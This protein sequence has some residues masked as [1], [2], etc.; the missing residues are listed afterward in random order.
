MH[1]DDAAPETAH[2][3]H[4]A[5]ASR[6]RRGA[7]ERP[8]AGA[9]LVLVVLAVA[10]AAAAGIAL[11][12]PTGPRQAQDPTEAG[13]VDFVTGR[14]VESRWATCEGTVEDVEPD[15][16]VP[17]DVRC[18]RVTAQVPD[19]GADGTVEVVA[20]AGLAPADVPEG[21][22][23]VL[24]RYP[25]ADGQPEVW[26]WGDFARGVPLL[27]LAV[28]FALLT[29]LVA[30]VRGLRAL[31]GLVLAFAVLGGYLLPAVVAGENALVVALCASAAIVVTVLYLAHGVSL[32]TTTALVG[33]LAGLALVTALGVAGAAL[34]HL[35]PVTSEDTFQLSRL[36]GDDGL[37]VLRGVFLC[38]VVLAG[39]GVLN[40][41]TITQASAVWELRAADPTAGVRQLFA[42]GMRIGR[43]HIASTVYTIAFAYAG[44]SLPVLLLLEVYSQPLARTLTSGAFAEEI[45]R[46]LA[47]SIGLV[48]AIPLTTAIAAVVAGGTPHAEVAADRG[49]V[50]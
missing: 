42:R 36:L 31:V 22:R 10:V 2:H 20:T 40:D 24:E 38:G 17:D 14:V 5:P 16:T 39:L 9:W 48:L 26:A 21:T 23:V 18:L 32:R 8:R 33:T 15:G 50:H 35:Q 27:A 11:T 3:R 4:V 44:A 29:V 30:G 47:G 7:G 13:A 37:D 43:D 25:A 34:A 41:V 1:P 45:V 19:G 6:P 12:W 28:V 49:H 46:T